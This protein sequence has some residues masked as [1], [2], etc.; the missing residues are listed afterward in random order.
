MENEMETGGICLQFG[1]SAQ[2]RI[3]GGGINR[4]EVQVISSRNLQV[5]LRRLTL[6]RCLVGTSCGELTPYLLADASGN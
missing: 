5:V 6:R 3:S 2:G 1:L 4:F